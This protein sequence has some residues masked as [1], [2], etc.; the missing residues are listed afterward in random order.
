MAEHTIVG[1]TRVVCVVKMPGTPPSDAAGARLLAGLTMIGSHGEDPILLVAPDD[2]PKLRKLGA[3]VTVIDND[4]N[5]Y[6]GR[7]LASSSSEDLVASVEKS[8]AKGKAD[9]AIA[10]TG[11]GDSGNGKA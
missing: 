11:G 9:L 1:V 3:E 2:I 5:H 4:G 8:V 6:A 7:I 10:Q